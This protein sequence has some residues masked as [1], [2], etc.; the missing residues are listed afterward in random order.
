VDSQ[1]AEEMRANRGTLTEA[2]KNSPYRSAAWRRTSISSARMRA[3]EFPEA[4]AHP[5]RQ[6]R[7]GEPQHQPARPGDLPHPPRHPP[8]H[9]RRVERI[10]P[11]Y[12]FAHPIEDAIEN[13]THSVCTLEFEDQ[14][15]FYDWLLDKLADRGPASRARCRSRSSSP[16]ST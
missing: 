6:G 1:S 12:T 2:G 11:M 9:R 10:Y 7:H 4:H 5:A 13:I 8:P 14:R 3:G 15:P 16:A